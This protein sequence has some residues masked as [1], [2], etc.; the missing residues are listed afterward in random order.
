[1][2]IVATRLSELKQQIA[3]CIDSGNTT[4]QYRAESELFQI[5]QDAPSGSGFDSGSS[6]DECSDSAMIFNTSFHHMNDHGTYTG[7]THHR[8]LVRAT[9]GGFDLRITGKNKNQIK[10]YIG[11]VFHTWLSTEVKDYRPKS[12]QNEEK[13][14]T[15]ALKPLVLDYKH[16]ED[17]AKP[18]KQLPA[19]EHK[20]GK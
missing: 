12:L 18:P 1:M 8:V 20:P 19:I 13:K 2:K 11:E 7:W 10:E 14:R 15:S 6:L 5:M 16:G 3:N 9:F 17:K 4:W